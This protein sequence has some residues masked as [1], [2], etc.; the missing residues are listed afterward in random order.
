MKE[1]FEEISNIDLF[2]TL[3]DHIIA[4]KWPSEPADILKKYFLNELFYFFTWFSACFYSK[5]FIIYMGC[6]Y[7]M[8][9]RRCA[10]DWLFKI[11]HY[12]E[13]GKSVEKAQIWFHESTFRNLYSLNWD[14]LAIYSLIFLINILK[15][16]QNDG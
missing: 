10:H 13:M 8:I 2:D 7:F 15:I 5:Y 4:D 12:T 9:F 6:N 16:L 3:L 11:S 1:F 14:S